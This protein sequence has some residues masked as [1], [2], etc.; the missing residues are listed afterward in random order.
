MFD[1]TSF[2][3]GFA[4][5]GSEKL[6]KDEEDA[7]TLGAA[8]VKSLYENYASVV[9]ENRT[10]SNDIKEKINVIKGF[11]P[12][13]TDDQLVALAQDRGILDMLS[14]RLK[15]KDFDATGFDINNFVAVTKSNSPYKAEERID[16]LF[17]IPSAVDSAS[18]AFK[19]I[20][21]EPAKQ[22]FLSLITG[23][24]EGQTRASAEQTAA[25]LGIPLGK[26]QG[27]MEYKRDIK[28]SGAGYNLMFLKPGD[29]LEQMRDKA[30]ASY[31]RALDKGDP[32]EIELA[33]LLV[34]NANKAKDALS[35]DQTRWVN[36]V[37]RLKG[38]QIKGTPQQKDAATK[39]LDAIYA[40]E[41]KAEE[42]KL[43]PKAQRENMIAKLEI[44]ANS[45]DPKVSGPAIA[46]LIKEAGTQAKVDAAKQTKIQQRDNYLADIDLKARTGTPEEQEIAKAK[47]VEM[48]KLDKL[49]EEAGQTDVQARANR[50][51]ALQTKAD[52]GDVAAKDELLKIAAIE[53]AIKEV[54]QTPVEKLAATKAQLVIDAAGGNKEAEAKLQ[55]FFAVEKMEADAKQGAAA[56]RK[57]LIEQ[58]KL[59]VAANKPGAQEELDRQEAIDNAIKKT[60]QEA[61]KGA[62]QKRADRLAE[63]ATLAANGNAEAQAEFNREKAVDDEAK[64]AEA[65]AIKGEAQKRTDKLAALKAKLDAGN[66]SVKAEYDAMVAVDIAA[67]VKEQEALKSDVAKRNDRI[68]SYQTTVTTSKDPTAVKEAKAQ[69]AKEM[70]IVAAEAKAKQVPTAASDKVPALGSLN[71]LAGVAAQQAVLDNH[72]NQKGN[73]VIID[74]VGSDGVAYKDYEYSGGDAV[75]AAQIKATKAAA[76]RNAMSVYTDN[77]GVPLNRDVQA[78]LNVWVGSTAAPEKKGGLGSKPA[79]EDAPAPAAAAAASNTTITGSGDSTVVIVTDKE[80]NQFKFEGADAARRAEGLK[81]AKGL[82]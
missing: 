6:D 10:L 60:A 53:A 68:A 29:T 77:K 45:D 33:K 50:L 16:Q 43:L 19:S 80:G 72:G 65:E 75:I 66:T 51:A 49:V 54:S 42:A 34:D 12:D 39:E 38:L 67:K 8:Q 47:L 20:T 9:K 73:M 37:A 74:K 40:E 24:R 56:K 5:A 2:G 13:A 31:K 36:N 59:D 41:R 82:K 79:A 70:A 23:S 35:D 57:D 7:K 76:V 62:A 26:L 28:P 30:G 52:N 63:L 78:I 18:K 1:W 4:K 25:A 14:T 21:P 27:V 58:L 32:K 48:K 11:A 46:K 22:G 81:K 69:L 44:D 17:T 64:R 15:D 55:A 61:V 71:S 3:T